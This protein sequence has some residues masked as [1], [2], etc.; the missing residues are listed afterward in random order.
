M[1]L[2]SLVT[3][4]LFSKKVKALP[5]ILGSR[6][7]FFPSARIGPITSSKGKSG[8]KKRLGEVS[9]LWK[10]TEKN[11]GRKQKNFD[12]FSEKLTFSAKIG[13][14]SCQNCL[15]TSYSKQNRPEKAI[16]KEFGALR[17]H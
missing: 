6:K 16:A 5:M 11:Y 1:T 15:K 4:S 12:F 2:K 13:F 14:F 3:P 9:E 8:L 17:G 7:N 10:V